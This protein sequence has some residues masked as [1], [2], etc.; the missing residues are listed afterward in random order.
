MEHVSIKLDSAIARQIE[1][2]LGE[3]NYTTKTEFIRDAIRGKL[4]ELDGERRKAKA[5]RALLA[6]YG[7]LKGQSKAKTDEEW[8]A[9]K[10]KAWDEF[11]RR[12]EQQ[13]NRK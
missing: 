10:L 5:E 8:R 4:K 7:S 1:R 2:A 9:L 6:A 3:F 12:R 11:N 13:T